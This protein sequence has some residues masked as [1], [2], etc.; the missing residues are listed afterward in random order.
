MNRQHL[1][2]SSS[3]SLVFARCWRCTRWS[4]GKFGIDLVTKIM[5][6]AI[7][8]LSLE[9]LVGSTGLVC[10]GQAAFFG[11]GAYAAVLLSPQGG[12][13]SLLWLLPAC[14]AA[15][16]RCTR[17]SSAR[18]RC[19]P[20]ACTSSWS[21]WPSRR[22]PTTSCTTRRW[23]AAPTAS[24][25]T[26]K[27]ALGALVD[28]DKPLALYYFTLACL[29]AGVRLPRAAAAL[30]LRP[31]AGRHPRQRAAHARDR[32]LDLS[33]QA[34]G[35][36]RSR[37]RI[38]GL[39]GFLFAVEGRLRQPGADELAPVGRGAD[40]DHPRRPRPP[41]RRADRRLRLRAAA[42]VLQ[43]RGD[44]RRLRQALAPGPGPG[45]HRQR[46]AAA[47]RAGRRCRRCG[48]PSAPN[49][50]ERHERSD[51]SAAR[52]R[53][54]APLG[55]PGGGGRRLDRARAR[56][57][58]RGDRHQRR[59][60]VDAD[61]HAVGRDCR[62]ATAR[63]SC[64]ARTSPRWTQPRR[65]RAGLGRSYQRNTI[66]PSFTVLENCRL[67]AQAA[68]PAAV[69]LVAVAQT[70]RGQRCRGARGRGA[71]RPGRRARPPGRPAVAT[72]QKRQLEIA[73]CL[74]TAPAG[75]AARRAA[76]RHGRRGDR[77]HAG[78]CWPS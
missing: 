38:A 37:A 72:A 17:S 35:L 41:A 9:L 48:A 78:S 3:S 26:S 61:Q 53:H 77:A 73:M 18:C 66:F 2:S 10:F 32:L 71:R 57:G 45:H 13:A 59:R 65:A 56:R 31:R 67:A 69:G 43:V 76:G 22:W 27:P 7:F 39:A 21:R 15:R 75:A 36:R 4:R 64:S 1:A 58:A 40:H 74:A 47:A 42:G 6:F 11:I 54:H 20:R 5:I 23:A 29:V 34:G 62:L 52:A 25:S 55:R 49:R 12:P 28:L 24:T 19:A 16:R 14:G 30:A 44:L 8:A 70:L 60:Q 46:G 50:R 63:S 51:M 68:T 33:V